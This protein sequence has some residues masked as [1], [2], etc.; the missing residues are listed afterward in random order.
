[1][2]EQKWSIHCQYCCFKHTHV[3]HLIYMS[4]LQGSPLQVNLFFSLFPLFPF[5]NQKCSNQSFQIRMKYKVSIEVTHLYSKIFFYIFRYQCLN[6]NNQI[7]YTNQ[8]SAIHIYL[9]N[10]YLSRFSFALKNN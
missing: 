8:I 9:M 1:M 5:I 7:C 2:K 6:V 3:L 10:L 4:S